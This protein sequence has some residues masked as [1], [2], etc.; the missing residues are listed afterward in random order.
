MD[1]YG[2]LILQLLIEGLSYG[3][4]IA[5]I[6]LGYTM[7]YGVVELI[8][9][10]HGDLFMLGCYA[11]LTLVGGLGL[12]T[13]TPATLCWA[14]P[15]IAILCA[16][17]GAL[18]NL[19]VERVIY[20][21]LRGAPKVTVLV[22]AIGLS[23]V[24]INL[25]LFWGGVPMEVFGGGR[26]PSSPKDFPNLIGDTTVYDGVVRIALKD[27]LVAAV[28]VPL[29][30]ALT[31][32]VK[33]TSLGRAM[34]AVAQAPTAARLMG[35][36]VDRVIA[37]TFAVGGALAGVAAVVYG[38]YITSVSFD[39]GFRMGLYAFTAAVLGGIGNLPGAVLGGLVIGV[40][41]SFSDVFLPTEWTNAIIFL[42]LI[43]L[44]V[45]RPTGLLGTSARE[46]V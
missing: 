4:I 35:I 22:T 45:F 31:W 29:L 3:M 42:V 44:L 37:I 36:D 39:M 30:I 11:A 24:F 25:G 15:L 19:G 5:L 28:T 9:F 26:A 41:R 23:F 27:V 17:F 13:A 6:A 46:K 16:A 10:A 7:V 8:N 12:A 18:V 21:P 38:L 34:R 32:M 33:G 40:A 43:L 14:L 2:W 20:R 1:G